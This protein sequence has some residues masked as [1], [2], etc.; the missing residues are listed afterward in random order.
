VPAALSHYLESP[1]IVSAWY[2]RILDFHFAMRGLAEL[3]TAYIVEY[4]RL[5]GIELEGS[6]VR[7]ASDPRSGCEWHFRVASPRSCARSLARSLASLPL[8]E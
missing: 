2:V 5:S 3:Q 7:Y 6:L 4:A 8:A 1:V